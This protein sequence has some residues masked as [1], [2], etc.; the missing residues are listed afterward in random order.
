MSN[1][2]QDIVFI[3]SA[4]LSQLLY[5]SSTYE[6]V[7]GRSCD[8][9]YRE[10]MSW[11]KA[12]RTE[13]QESILTV[14]KQQLQGKL[15]H[16]N[17]QILHPSGITRW[18]HARTLT[19]DDGAYPLEQIIIL[20]EDITERQQ[21]EQ[22]LHDIHR[23]L[24]ISSECNQT[25]IR[26]VDEN[27]LVQDIC[28]KVV[29]LGGYSAAWIGFV[30]Q[31]ADKRVRP[32]AHAGEINQYLQ[33][34]QI[35][36][37]N[38]KRG[39]TC[40]GTTIRTS[41]ICVV[42]DWQ[43]ESGHCLWHDGMRQSHYAAS[44]ALPL[45]VNG[46]TIG[47]FELYS[48]QPNEFDAEE[49]QLLTELADNLACRL[50]T[51]RTQ[52]ELQ[53][54]E[55]KFRAFLE[56]AS[57]GVIIS[58]SKGEVVGFNAKAEELFGYVASE[59]LGQ[60]IETLMPERFRQGHIRFR[61]E[62]ALQPSQ[63]SMGH[64]R[65]LY[66]LRKDGSEFPIAA[67][68]S[69]V[70]VG[71][72]RFIL[73]LVTDI[74]DRQQIEAERQ[75]VEAKLR[76]SEDHLRHMVELNPQVPWTADATGNITD[77][78]E[79][80]LR[81]T[82]LTREQAL[83]EGWTQVPHPDDRPAMVAAWTHSVKTGDAYD[84]EHR[85]KLADGSY[86]WMRSRAFPRLDA[87]G[88]IVGW[89]GTTEDIHETKLAEAQLRESEQRFRDMADNA[90]VMIWV[91]S[92]TGDCTYLSKSWYDFTGQTETTGLGVGWIDAIHIDD[93]EFAKAAF[94][95]ANQ[96]HENFYVEYRLRH[97]DGEY[98]WV[99]DAAT[100]WFGM[101]GEFK[102]HIGS[103][104]DITDRKQAEK[105]LQ[106]N[107]ARLRLVHTATRSGLWDW[108]IRQNCAHVSEEYCVLFGIHPVQQTVSYNQWLSLVHPDDRAS[109]STAINNM[110]QQRQDYY[111]DEY[112]VLHSN[113]IRWLAG[114][115]QIFYDATGNPVRM[116]GTMQDITQRKQAEIALSQLNED[117]EQRVRDRTVELSQLNQRLQHELQ[118]RVLIQQRLAEQAQLLDLAHDPIITRDPDGTIT[119][120]NSGATQMYG[121]T[122][123]EALGQSMH[124]LLQTQFPYPLHDINAE[125]FNSHYWEG[126]LTHR[127]HDG[128]PI[129][130]ASRWVLQC[131]E[132]GNPVKVLEINN[133]IT[134]SKQVEVVQSRLAAIIQSSDDAIISTTLNGIIES[135]NW[136]AEKLYGYSALEVIGQ[137]ITLLQPTN[138]LHE[139]SHL[140]EQ[141]QQGDLIEHYETV[142]QHKDGHL[143][144]ISLTVSPIKNAA[145][146]I[147][148]MSKIA[149]NI[150]KRKQVEEQLRIS[151]ERISLANAELARAARL[152]DEFLAGMSHELR[153]PLNAILGLSEALL[154][155]IFGQLTPEQREHITT[156]EQS[157]KHLLALI[158]DILDLSKIESG[159][160]ELEVAP[161]IVKELCESSL[162]FVKQQAHHKRIKIHYQIDE[163]LTEIEVDE[164]RVRQVLVNLLSNAVKFTP[165]GGKVQL[166]VRADSFLETVQLSVTDTGIGIA[167]ENINKLFQPFVQLDSALSRRYS[168]TGL[169]LALVRRIAELHGGSVTLDSQEGK[170]S[171]FTVT[172][173]W[174]NPMP[175][176]TVS[177]ESNNIKD[178][179]HNFQQALI[180]EDSQVAANQIAR[181]L[182]ELGAKTSVHTVGRGAVQ[183][184]AQL[185]PDV[186][187]LDILLPDRSGWDVLA[188]LKA[189]PLTQTIPVVVV[190]VV[191]DRARAIERGATAYLLKPIS[192]QQLQQTL[193][194]VSLNS[195]QS[196]EQTALI[197][198][199]SQTSK[200]PS[201]L[202]AEDNEANITTLNSYLQAHGFQVLLARNG[203]EAI[204]LAKQHRPNLILMDIQMPEMDGLEAIHRIQ[205][206]EHLDIPIV[207]LTALAMPGDRER[208]IAAGAV[209]YLTKPVS[210]KT[211][212]S[213]LSQHMPQI[214]LEGSR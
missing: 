7:W 114:R 118:E 156:I 163:E 148:G 190:S 141:M 177:T 52:V 157:G 70:N 78:N 199:A 101:D 133:D 68:L 116:L 61:A 54:N 140:I 131:D 16:Q 56:M 130:V 49:V 212:M 63:R 39:Q 119:F 60:P 1:S 28:C 147:T 164:R 33:T 136:G 201:I 102:G 161:V 184:A 110:I 151:N 160:M 168:G 24:H 179:L 69:T 29:E 35:T 165:D 205:T 82:G 206:E 66:A 47:V 85:V 211:L 142:R 170:G 174:H 62:Y 26:A 41:Q 173:P 10:P 73:T 89:Y 182:N 198:A 20:A 135:W 208:C 93:R 122:Q 196:D 50:I 104:I 77:F 96:C 2:N 202:L 43:N 155:E 51:L 125:L 210:L 112:R 53:Q 17:Y 143:I 214:D 193:R 111:E 181:Y 207:A 4:D 162:N 115:G 95:Q 204:E 25:L 200:M 150:S 129:T 197:L 83:G 94:L 37:A 30:E 74:S 90:P 203:L 76:E 103:V 13:D 46:Q 186:I 100:P 176:I 34:S 57:E 183:L 38:N 55:T 126:E 132:N 9:L 187:I 121:W 172:L 166:Q 12:L 159:K 6:H 36:W 88:H 42:E 11:A 189:N 134:S 8:S 44:I 194:Q 71:N 58:N 158:N 97:Q 188:D 40:I 139:G 180:V 19:R 5:V 171:R 149:R 64:A 145:G 91:T 113:E 109:A 65:N 98:R 169:G 137:P 178:S 138:N 87:A 67:G 3:Y 21:S 99:I 31:D 72:E 124:A 23:S 14:F 108:D 22:K 18:I 123:N 80:W 128:T 48:N 146:E 84:I 209:D 45:I 79:R 81:L 86:R 185:Q 32:V 213:I 153:T 59:I 144:D 154:E 127:R 192:R 27:T 92:P 175:S 120:W 15:F 167:P 107:E 117:L 106:E 191:D 105:A 195:E 75:A 152:K